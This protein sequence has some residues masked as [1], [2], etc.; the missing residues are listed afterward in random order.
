M[1][2][3]Q[4]KSC[5]W[6]GL[7]Q[8][9][10]HYFRCGSYARH[11]DCSP[12]TVNLDTFAEVILHDINRHINFVKEDKEKY[13]LQLMEHF[14]NGSNENL[15]SGKEKLKRIE[16]RIDKLNLL[17][18]KIYE[19]K[20][21][22]RITEAIYS[23]MYVNMSNELNSLQE[24]Q[25]LLE[26]SANEHFASEKSIN[27]FMDLLEQYAPVKKLDAV[28]LNNLIEKIVVHE[29]QRIDGETIM[30]IEI[31]YRF[32]GKVEDMPEN[33]LLIGRLARTKDF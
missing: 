23:A 12:H 18:Q 30:P 28:L 6:K 19:D 4:S 14:N 17:I 32:V 20:T 31:Y 15:Q 26:N 8:T 9:Q 10:S 16:N 11:R 29:R 7:R 24:E 5:F 33:M 27:G 2:R 1:R 13:A 21:F 25:K 22:G 3:M